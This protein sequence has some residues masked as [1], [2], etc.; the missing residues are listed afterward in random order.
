MCRLCR[1]RAFNMGSVSAATAMPCFT[2]GQ[3][4]GIR[5]LRTAYIY[6]EVRDAKKP[7]INLPWRKV[8][9]LS[10]GIHAIRGGCVLQP[11]R[12]ALLVVFFPRKS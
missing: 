2:S 5:P 6:E 1:L 8:G 9:I 4:G 11:P 3:R 7:L 12:I 10:V